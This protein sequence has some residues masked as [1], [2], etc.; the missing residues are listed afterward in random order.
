MQQSSLPSKADRLTRHVRWSQTDTGWG[1]DAEVTL[2]LVNPS[3]P[4]RYEWTEGVNDNW[5]LWVFVE[6]A[7]LQIED[8][9]LMDDVGL[10][11]KILRIDEFTW[12]DGTFHHYELVTEEHEKGLSDLDNLL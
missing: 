8:I 7:D 3:L 12:L 11:L 1:G 5:N 4:A 2:T 9:V 6:D 10:A